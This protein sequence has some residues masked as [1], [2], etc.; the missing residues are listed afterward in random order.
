M[1]ARQVSNVSSSTPA[2]FRLLL[3]EDGVKSVLACSAAIVGPDT[4][5]PPDMVSTGTTVAP[6]RDELPL[7]GS[8]FP[9]LAQAPTSNPKRASQTRVLNM[10]HLRES[11]HEI[12]F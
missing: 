3:A 9:S 7:D 6:A 10:T 8:C 11:L 2:A 4:A 5:A 12:H 1:R